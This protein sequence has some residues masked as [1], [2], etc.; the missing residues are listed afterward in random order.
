MFNVQCLSAVERGCAESQPQQRAQHNGAKSIRKGFGLATP[1]RLVSDTAALRA[2]RRHPKL[3]LTHAL[4]YTT[5][6]ELVEPG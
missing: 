5:M 6:N 1:L 2:A 3:E 4:G